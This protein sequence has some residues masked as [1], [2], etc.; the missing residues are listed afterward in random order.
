V[1][2]DQSLDRLSLEQAAR[3]RLGVEKHGCWKATQL[4]PQPGCDWHRESSLWPVEDVAWDP[5][6]DSGLEETFTRTARDFRRERESCSHLHEHVI[7]Q[8]RPNFQRVC[9]ARDVHLHEQL[10][11]KVRPSV[12]VEKTLDQ[13]RRVRGLIGFLNYA[14][15]RGVASEIGRV[16][17]GALGGIETRNPHVVSRRRVELDCSRKAQRAGASTVLHAACANPGEHL[18]GCSSERSGDSLQFPCDLVSDIAAVPAEALVSTVSVECNRD[19]STCHLGQIEAGDRRGVRK[20][21]AVVPRKT[22]QHI[23]YTRFDNK[24]VV[25]GIEELSNLEGIPSLVGMGIVEADSESLDS[26]G[27]LLSHGRND[28]A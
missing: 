11:R 23:D 9:H 16:E 1:G 27:S 26:A 25:L 7:E 17:R 4:I 24:L 14:V 22:R 21:F 12:Y 8:R 6:S 20:W 10:A 13:G 15:C 3:T 2:R 18:L 19:V 5:R 28:C